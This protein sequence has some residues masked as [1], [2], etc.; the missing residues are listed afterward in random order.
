MEHS[1]VQTKQRKLGMLR[2][3]S[4]RLQRCQLVTH[5][6]AAE[7]L[8]WFEIWKNVAVSAITPEKLPGKVRNYVTSSG[9]Y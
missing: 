5:F 7:A 4:S 9:T 3:A 8:E 1:H 2:D 6:P